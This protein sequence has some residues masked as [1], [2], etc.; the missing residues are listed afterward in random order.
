MIN[1]YGEWKANENYNDFPKEKWCDLDYVAAW[2]KGLN[3]EAKTSI[4]NLCMM[5]FEGYDYDE[6]KA[7]QGYY[8]IKD[9]REYPEC[10]MVNIPDVEVYVE[11]HG[12]L[13]EFDYYC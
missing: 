8:A 10:L 7:E 1:Y 2:I 12:G 5:I 4:E 13:A 6:N 3:Y 11:E 9:E